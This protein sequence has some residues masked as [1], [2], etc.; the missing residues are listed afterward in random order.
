MSRI[1]IP[2][3]RPRRQSGIALL[4]GLIAIVIFSL[5]IIAIVGLQTMAVKQSTDARYRSEAG[6]LANQLIGQM[7]VTDRTPATLQ[8]TFESGG[9]GYNAWLASVTSAL[10]GA[11]TYPPTV[12]VSATGEVTVA[13]FWLPPSEGSSTTPHRYFTV[14]QIR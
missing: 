3:R 5:G 11:A 1:S 6:V 9:A 7:W 2:L 4:E 10:P 12:N 14:A 13:V 8:A